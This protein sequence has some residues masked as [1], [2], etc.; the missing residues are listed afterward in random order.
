MGPS[1]EVLR[2]KEYTAGQ[3]FEQFLTIH[4]TGPTVQHAQALNVSSASEVTLEEL[5]PTDHLPPASWQDDPKTA[6]GSKPF[7][8]APKSVITL[9][10]G[11]QKPEHDVYFARAKEL[12]VDNDEAF[13]TI[14][15]E[16]GLNDRPLV[17]LA[18]FRKFWDALSLM[19]DY[20][21]TSQ[22]QYTNGTTDENKETMGPVQSDTPAKLTS[23]AGRRIGT[24]REM[25]PRFRDEA[26]FTFVETIGFAFRCKVDRP[27]TEPKLKVHNLLIPLLQTGSVY[28]YPRDSQAARKGLLEGPLLGIQCTNQM[29]FRRPDEAQETVGQG[30]LANFL[31][32]I[33]LMLSIAEKR[34][35]E[36]RTEPP[37]GESEWWLT[38]PRWGGAPDVGEIGISEEAPKELEFKLPFLE[39]LDNLERDNSS[40]AASISSSTKRGPVPISAPV[41][42]TTGGAADRAFRRQQQDS[43]PSSAGAGGDDSEG[44]AKGRKRTKRST[45]IDSWKNLQPSTSSW[46][47]NVIYKQIGRHKAATHDDVS[48]HLSR[49][50]S[51]PFSSHQLLTNDASR[52]ESQIYIISSLMHHISILHCRI[53]PSYTT[54]LSNP[55]PYPH[56]IPARE[57]WYQLEVRRSRWF[58]LMKRED[59]ALAMRGIWGVMDFLM[60]DLGE[61]GC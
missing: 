14:R 19:A 21:D 13:R 58:D 54:Y 35:R 8:S 23:Y 24:G 12:L 60:R 4:K 49:F 10:N 56:F 53:H 16:P 5:L 9:S 25:P 15:R 44:S 38:K 32:E 11:T 28:R 50:L 46:E 59:R 29:V 1:S 42:R 3:I 7:Q 39:T 52:W 30:D 2:R 37:P 40:L 22:D 6:G 17:R 33:G 18:H 43:S 61:D 51:L 57:P 34:S 26:V 47:K 27:R 55:I 31:R 41:G 36:G 45:A 20:W 48:R